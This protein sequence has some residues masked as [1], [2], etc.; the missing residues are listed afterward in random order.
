M[1]TLDNCKEQIR[2][3]QHDSIRR[4]R[5]MIQII[6]D[7][8]DNGVKSIMMLDEQHERLQQCANHTETIN[9][10]L[11]KSSNILGKI[12]HFIFPRKACKIEKIPKNV[13]MDS[14]ADVEV[15][16]IHSNCNATNFVGS[17]GS[18]RNT[19][20]KIKSEFVDKNLEDELDNNLDE[21]NSGLTNLKHMAL[22]I[23]KQLDI[24]NKLLE[25]VNTNSA[26]VNKNINKMNKEINKIL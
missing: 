12:K 15:N 22:N 16:V 19:N 18:A 6:T 14:S 7:A 5:D 9:R 8:E 25:C 4:T 10:N 24:D 3:I 20:V 21:I 23:N 13:D 1:G 2:N 26:I 17:V 11:E